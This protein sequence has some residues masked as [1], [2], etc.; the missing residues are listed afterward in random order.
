MNSWAS[1]CLMDTSHLRVT[2]NAYFLLLTHTRQ[3]L[4]VIFCDATAGIGSRKGCRTQTDRHEGQLGLIAD[5][6]IEA[7]TRVEFGDAL[8]MAIIRCS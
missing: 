3:L 6:V 5:P 4:L 1:P 2:K 7:I 8:R